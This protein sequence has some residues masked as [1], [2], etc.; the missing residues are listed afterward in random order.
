R[1]AR[2]APHPPAASPVPS[3]L[4][5][6]PAP[7]RAAP[8]NPRK[9]KAAPR[10]H[11]AAVP[12]CAYESSSSDPN[13]TDPNYA[14]LPTTATQFHTHAPPRYNPPHARRHLRRLPLE[15]LRPPIP[16][17]P[18]LRPRQRRMH[19]HRETGPPPRPHAPHPLGPPGPRQM[20]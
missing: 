18:R 17:P 2:L 19:P 5:A 6:A 8:H 1:S 4:S 14:A 10:N 15:H 11:P 12:E 3:S 13:P 20:V 7:S 16:L 9:A